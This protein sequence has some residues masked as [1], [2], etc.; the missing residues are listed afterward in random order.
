MLNYLHPLQAHSLVARTEPLRELVAIFAA[1]D[2]ANLL[3]EQEYRCVLEGG[4][5]FVLDSMELLARRLALGGM[6]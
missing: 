2:Y 4:G 6:L 3:R 5:D 1:W